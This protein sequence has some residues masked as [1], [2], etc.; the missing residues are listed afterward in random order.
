MKKV[1]VAGAGHG[2]L[3][4]GRYLAEAGFDV[5]VYEAKQEADLGYDQYDSV[6]IDG[7]ELAGVPVPEAYKVKRTGLTFIIPGTD[8]PPLR[9]GVSED[10]YNVEIDRKALYRWLIGPAKEAGVKFEFG[11]K[12]KAPIMLGSRVAGLVTD[13]GDIYADLVID[14]AGLYS[15]VRMQLPEALGIQNEATGT[16]ILHTYRAF[17]K[18]DLTAGEP[19]YKYIVSLIPGEDC[20][21]LWAITGEEQVDILIASMTHEIDDAYIELRT[22][23][24]KAANPVIGEFIRGGRVADIPVRQPLS[25]LVAD[26]YAAI[27]DAAF[28]TIPLKGSGVGHS[29]RAGRILAETVIADEKGFYNRETLWGY[30]VKYFEQMGNGSMLMAV[31]KNELPYISQDDL[32]YFFRE[33]I[34]SDMLEAF[35]SE[36]KFTGILS[37]VK[38]RELREK[39]RKIVGHPHVRS[40]I[41]R[42]GKN[43]TRCMMAQ[44]NLKEK[45]ETKSANKWNASYNALFGSILEDAA[46]E[47]EKAKDPADLEAEAEK[48]AKK[49]EKEKK[50]E[51]KKEE[52]KEKKEKKDKKEKA[53]AADEA[54]S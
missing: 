49:L 23:Q 5:T 38:F 44:Q 27:G 34:S 54:E 10:T 18:R 3:V 22:A 25:M 40:M 26:G 42:G 2:G 13:K 33:I 9:Q 16:D 43:I 45:Y 11:C 32:E 8:L 14:A 21:I 29:M 36:A 30:Q 4:A 20:G 31:I 28:M 39:A 7:F 17:F 37:S 51:E 24:L 6:H 19:E 52:K 53:E 50:K 46:E 35:G 47:S 12:V 41:V 1:I 15:P 48:A